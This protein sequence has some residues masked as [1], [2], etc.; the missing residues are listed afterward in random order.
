MDIKTVEKYVKRKTI[1]NFSFEGANFII[2]FTDETRLHVDPLNM[3]ISYEEKI[4][5]SYLNN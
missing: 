5:K 4:D 1:K 2:Y 3:I